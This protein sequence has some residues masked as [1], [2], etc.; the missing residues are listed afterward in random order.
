M[1]R[2][3]PPVAFRGE[4]HLIFPPEAP[5]V[6][7]D[8]EP[9]ARH[10]GPETSHEAA[11]YVLEHEIDIDQAEEAARALRIAYRRQMRDYTVAELAKV[12][13]LDQWMLSK[14]MSVCERRGLVKRTPKRRCMVT[15][16]SAHGWL[17]VLIESEESKREAK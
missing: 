6:K 15:E 7:S 13:G 10:D 11:A 4:Q 3:R 14:R 16:H 12:S 17:P 9:I 8:R 5:Y 1:A 2:R